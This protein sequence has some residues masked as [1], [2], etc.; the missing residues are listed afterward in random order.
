[1]NIMSGGGLAVGEVDA[2][3]LRTGE[4]RGKEDVQD[5]ERGHEVTGFGG[6]C[7]R[8]RRRSAGMW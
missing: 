1:M 8:T 6:I 2:I 4:S 7:D 3:S 5:A